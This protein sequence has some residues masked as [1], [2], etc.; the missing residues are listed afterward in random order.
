MTKCTLARFEDVIIDGTSENPVCS[1]RPVEC[2]GEI[3][4]GRAFDV[5]HRHFY[6]DK[7]GVR[8]EKLPEVK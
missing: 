6:C 3:K 2:G 8:Y 7:C 4:Q 1:R 5:Q